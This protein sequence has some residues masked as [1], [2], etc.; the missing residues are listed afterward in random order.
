MSRRRKPLWL[1]LLMAGLII[2]AWLAFL[3]HQAASIDCATGVVESC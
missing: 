1:M 3:R 2:A